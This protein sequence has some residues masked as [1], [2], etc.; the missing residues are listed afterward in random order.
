MKLNLRLISSPSQLS[1]RRSQAG[2][3]WP[4]GRRIGAA[5]VEFA[6]VAPLLVLLVTG[7]LE[8]GRMVMVQQVLTNASREGAR[9]AIVGNTTT[10]EVE[11]VV[12]DYTTAGGI[13]SVTTN[14]TPDPPNTAAY[15]DPVSVTVSVPFSSTSWVPSPFFLGSTTLSATSVMRRESLD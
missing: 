10:G 8:F 15:G 11:E 13:P 3:P 6:V 14:I 12:A 7:M 1:L 2:G 5:V 9:A 4:L